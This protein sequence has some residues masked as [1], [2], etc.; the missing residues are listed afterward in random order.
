VKSTKPDT[1]DYCLALVWGAGRVVIR[2]LLIPLLALLVTLATL[3]RE[4]TQPRL[5]KAAATPAA[6]LAIPPSTEPALES[7][8]VA[9][10]RQLA[11]ADG[12]RALARSG[13]RQQL[14]KVLA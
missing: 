1:I 12:H 2:D 8:T 13:R 4:P 6:P 7:C 10:L 3:H 5:I 14:L 11:R 9:Q